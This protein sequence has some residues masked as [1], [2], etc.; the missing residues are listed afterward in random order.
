V[1]AQGAL[2]LHLLEFEAEIGVVFRDPGE[3]RAG[4]GRGPSIRDAGAA[5]PKGL[6]E[7]FADEVAAMRRYGKAVNRCHT[8]AL[9]PYR[10]YCLSHY[11]YDGLCA[12]LFV[13]QESNGFMAAWSEREVE[14]RLAPHTVL[15]HGTE[16]GLHAFLRHAMLATQGRA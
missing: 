3:M 14:N 6:L 4:Q 10:A 9:P 11:N 12:M 2:R 1:E 13:E 16:A 15:V 5:T 8:I 7:S